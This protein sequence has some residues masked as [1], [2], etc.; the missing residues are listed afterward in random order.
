MAKEYVGNTKVTPKT[1]NKKYPLA[2][3]PKDKYWD[4]SYVNDEGTGYSCIGFARMVLDATYGKG[5]PLDTTTFTDANS[6]KTA[7]DDIEKG[8]RVTFKWQPNVSSGQHGIIVA[9]KTSKGITAYD[10][11]YLLD[12]MIR[13]RTWT[14]QFILDEFSQVIGGY[15]HA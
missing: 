3:L 13:Y 8:A 14:W 5:D 15:H 2:D 12:A 11:N 7:F 9:G 6:V 10:C 1:W 4:G